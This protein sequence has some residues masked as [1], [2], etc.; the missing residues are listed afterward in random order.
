MHVINSIYEW[1]S[2]HFL[3]CEY[4]SSIASIRLYEVATSH[5]ANLILE[6]ASPPPAPF[7]MAEE[8]RGRV[9]LC[10]DLR[11]HVYQMNDSKFD[12]RDARCEPRNT[13]GETPLIIFLHWSFD[14]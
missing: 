12:H 10:P 5:R 9:T 14:S 1:F 2:S 3:E 8:V 13:V 6:Y 11:C 4:R 7:Q